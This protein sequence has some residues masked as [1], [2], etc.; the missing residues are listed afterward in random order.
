MSPQS[1]VIVASLVVL[2]LMLGFL[3]KKVH[4]TMAKELA[5]VPE[6]ETN[7]AS[8]NGVWGSFIAYCLTSVVLGFQMLGGHAT[9]VT[10]WVFGPIVGATVIA[11]LWFGYRTVKQAELIAAFAKA[12]ADADEAMA[13]SQAP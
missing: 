12:K 5:N 8:W 4:T 6:D 11:L 1:I 3:A 9:V 2:A 13:T 10:G 7:I